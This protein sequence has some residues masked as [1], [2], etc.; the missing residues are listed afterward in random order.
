MNF[1]V[2][3]RPNGGRP[4]VPFVRHNAAQERAMA[5]RE[6][7][8][9]YYLKLGSGREQV[10]GESHDRYHVG[11]IKLRSLQ[12]EP[13]PG[14]VTGTGQAA[15]R[16]RRGC[17]GRAVQVHG[18]QLAGALRR[19]EQRKTLQVGS[20]R[21]CRRRYRHSTISHELHR[22]PV[23]SFSQNPDVAP[24]PAPTE[25]PDQLPNVEYNYN[26][27]RA[28]A[29]DLLQSIFKSLGLARPT[30]RGRRGSRKSW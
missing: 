6:K 3:R 4:G 12:F 19:G 11:W 22:R 20:A 7:P 24:D 16:E 18:P 23:A 29:L 28:D 21:G 10:V 13:S 5:P 27:V 17:R 25:L 8:K 9:A 2:G 1:A 26:P 14:A 30:I 15:P